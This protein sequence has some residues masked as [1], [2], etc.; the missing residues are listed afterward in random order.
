M[1]YNF[2]YE[3]RISWK[4]CLLSFSMK[5]ITNVDVVLFSLQIWIM[6]FENT[7]FESE[8]AFFDDIWHELKL[9]HNWIDQ[10]WW[11]FYQCETEK[12]Y[13]IMMKEY[14]NLLKTIHRFKNEN[15]NILSDY[16]QDILLIDEYK[17]TWTRNIK[18][19]N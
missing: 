6:S 3:L 12:E 17:E 4:R 8:E 18:I 10:S 1:S 16:K 2:Y 5:G 14:L 11:W 9:L 15:M 7:R 13:N 19:K